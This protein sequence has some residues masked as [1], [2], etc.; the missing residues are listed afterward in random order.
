MLIV[1]IKW[2]YFIKQGFN[3]KKDFKWNLSNIGEDHKNE[4]DK[5][6]KKNNVS[7]INN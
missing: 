5:Y 4:K 2:K 3:Q 6:N 1:I 7:S